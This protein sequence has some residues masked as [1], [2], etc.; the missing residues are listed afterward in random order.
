MSQKGLRNLADKAQSDEALLDEIRSNPE[1]ALQQFDLT[2]DERE[3]L[4]TGS[5]A[6]VQELLSGAY[7]GAANES[8]TIIVVA[9][10]VV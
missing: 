4:L 10:V 8:P 5:P 1:Q 7:A 3:Q 9:P 6:D 2:D